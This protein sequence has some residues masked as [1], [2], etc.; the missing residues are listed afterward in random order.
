MIETRIQKLAGLPLAFH[1]PNQT[2]SA[3]WLGLSENSQIETKV[4]AAGRVCRGFLQSQ[5]TRLDPLLGQRTA[6]RPR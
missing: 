2:Q 6:D 5:A 4:I 3:Q 1:F